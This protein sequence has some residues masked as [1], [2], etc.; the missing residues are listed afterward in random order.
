MSPTSP[1]RPTRVRP[2]RKAVVAAFGAAALLLAA[3]A[4]GNGDDRTPSSQGYEGSGPQNERGGPGVGGTMPGANGKIAAVA[5]STAQVQ[6]LDGQVAVSWTG[7]TTFTKEVTATLADV[8]V[9]S[10]VVVGPAGDLSSSSTPATAVTA[11]SVRIAPKRNGSC[12]MALRGPGGPAGADPQLNGTPPKDA[13]SGAPGG[14]QRPQVRGLGG[15]VGE[16]TAVSA[17]GFTVDSVMP[18]TDG[19]TSVAVSVGADTT[20]STTAPGAASDVKVGSCLVASGPTD[21]TGA[22]T[23]TNVALSQPVDGQCGGMMRFRSDGGGA[24]TQESS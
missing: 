17:S 13:P 9:G 6:G 3:S 12:G 2:T 1:L 23:A 21:D 14:G 18:G 8:K 20:Y 7:S 5:G 16:V 10:C 22:V 19:K 24:S 11:A 4:C 15:A